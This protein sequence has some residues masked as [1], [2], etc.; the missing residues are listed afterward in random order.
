MEVLFYS[1]DASQWESLVADLLEL[2]Y[3]PAY[4]KSTNNNYPSLKDALQ[5]NATRLDDAAIADMAA[6]LLADQV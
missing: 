3:D 1:I 5:L 4:R 2:H 6:I